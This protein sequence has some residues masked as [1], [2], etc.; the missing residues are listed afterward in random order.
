MS[1][2]RHSEEVVH[3]IGPECTPRTQSS[4]KDSCLTT[5][6]FESTTIGTVGAADLSISTMEKLCWV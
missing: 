3:G 2:I 5:T 4:T 6:S 1:R